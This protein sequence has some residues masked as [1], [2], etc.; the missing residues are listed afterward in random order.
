MDDNLPVKA[1]SHSWVCQRQ[2][3][4]VLQGLIMSRVFI[5][6]LPPE[7]RRGP[8]INSESLMNSMAFL[9][10]CYSLSMDIACTIRLQAL[11]TKVVRCILKGNGKLR[12]YSK[13]H[14]SVAYVYSRHFCDISRRC[15]QRVRS[16]LVCCCFFVFFFFSSIIF[17]KIQ[18]FVPDNKKKQLG[19]S[20]FY[21][22]KE[23]LSVQQDVDVCYSNPFRRDL[24]PK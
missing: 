13:C 10:P 9:L 12:K 20:V 15:K 18:V 14:S 16:L 5:L 3:V 24:A 23:W 2:G 17:T 21:K 6:L 1:K 19:L 22:S 7:A 11:N 4:A 8:R